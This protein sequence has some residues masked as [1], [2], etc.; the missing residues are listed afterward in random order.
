MTL[1]DWFQSGFFYFFFIFIKKVYNEIKEARKTIRKTGGQNCMLVSISQ[2][3]KDAQKGGYAIPSPDFWDSSSA[4]AFVTVAEKLHKPVILSYSQTHENFLSLEEAAFIGRF[5][6]ETVNVPVALHLDQGMDFKFIDA[7]IKQGFTS[8]MI[9]ASQYSFEENVRLTKEVVEFAHSFSIDVEAEIG[10]VGSEDV[11]GTHKL[12]ENVYT[13]PL[14]AAEFV[15]QTEC[16]CLSVSI[17]TSHGAYKN[18]T[19]KID[20]ETLKE[21]RK[22]VDVPLVLH[23]GSGSGDENLHKC[24]QLGICK[25]NIFTDFIAGALQQT[26][27]HPQNTW[28]KVMTEAEKK[29]M[30]I[31]EHYYHVLGCD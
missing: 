16:D 2:I 1:P 8:V 30:E 22:V 4:R 23:G 28:T 9:D 15:R 31:Q 18:G 6:A 13:D 3:L 20:F 29:I 11:N 17:G 21:I 27:R 12:S 25:V 14:M 7:A 10:N 19:P 26:Y 5:Y 24:A